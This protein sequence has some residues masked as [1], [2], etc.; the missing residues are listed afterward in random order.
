ML[1]IHPKET[2]YRTYRM[3]V[4]RIIGR[5]SQNN[6]LYL[7]G[8]PYYVCMHMYVC[9]YIYI[10]IHMYVYIYK[11]TYVPAYIDG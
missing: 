1:L 3:T 2:N 10:Y 6:L 5:L 7:D 11:Y 9:V 8:L 4:R